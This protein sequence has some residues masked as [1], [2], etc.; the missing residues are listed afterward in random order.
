LQQHWNDLDIKTAPLAELAKMV[1]DRKLKAVLDPISPLPFT[2]DDVKRG[3]HLM[4]S[5]HAH[6]KVVVQVSK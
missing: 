2:S 3:F 4:D 5:R 1:D 6:G